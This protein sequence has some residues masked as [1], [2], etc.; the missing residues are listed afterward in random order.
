[1]Q[2]TQSLLACRLV[3][4]RNA[5]EIQRVIELDGDREETFTS[6]PQSKLAGLSRE[7]VEGTLLESGLW[8]ALR[9][10]VSSDSGM[11]I[12]RCYRNRKRT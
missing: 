12:Q 3:A 8:T 4:Q 6:F 7:Q 9:T 11:L 10:R 1:M 5:N 2:A